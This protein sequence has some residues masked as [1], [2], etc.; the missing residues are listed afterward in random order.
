L[1][2]LAISTVGGDARDDDL[3]SGLNKQPEEPYEV[4]SCSTVERHGIRLFLT[5]EYRWLPL[6]VYCR[7]RMRAIPLKPKVPRFT[8]VPFDIVLSK[9]GNMMYSKFINH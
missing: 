8:S 9:D 1:T 3:P 4:Q 2:R 5:Y 6:L 7:N